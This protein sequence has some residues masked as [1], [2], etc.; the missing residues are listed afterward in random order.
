[1]VGMRL[2]CTATA[3]SHPVLKV[4]FHAKRKR[5]WNRNVITFEKA[6]YEEILLQALAE[7]TFQ[8]VLNL[9]EKVDSKTIARRCKKA[10]EKDNKGVSAYL[11]AAIF[12][13]Y[14]ILCLRVVS[15]RQK[16]DLALL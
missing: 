11:K 13:Y 15:W 1:V 14:Y 8:A 4:G 3:S 9:G 2:H 16:G 12:I 5:L 7:G 6:I 10:I